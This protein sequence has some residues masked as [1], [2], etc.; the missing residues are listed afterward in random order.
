M[1]KL[2]WKCSMSNY[3]QVKLALMVCSFFSLLW[4]SR[5]FSNL[6]SWKDSYLIPSFRKILIPFIFNCERVKLPSMSCASD[7]KVKQVRKN[8]KLLQV[9]NKKLRSWCFCSNFGWARI[10]QKTKNEVK[11]ELYKTGYFAPFT[12]S[13]PSELRLSNFS[14]RCAHW[15]SPA[16]NKIKHENEYKCKTL[17]KN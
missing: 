14:L 17:Q 3:V 10:N 9:F 4:Q 15:L 16:H 1:W 12:E 6:P 5:A 2:W 7:N 13:T 11:R 8:L